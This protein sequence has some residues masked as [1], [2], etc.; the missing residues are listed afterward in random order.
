MIGLLLLVTATGSAQAKRDP[1]EWI[2]AGGNGGYH[3]Y[4]PYSFSEDGRKVFFDTEEPLVPSDIDTQ[5]DT[6]MRSDGVTTLLS[7]GPN[8]GNGPYFSQVAGNSPDGSHA[9]FN[10]SESLVSADTDRQSDLYEWT[11]G[12]TRLVST[13]PSG[14]NGFYDVCFN[15]RTGGLCVGTKGRVSRDGSRV[16]FE[17]QESLVAADTDREYDVYQRAGGET[18]LISTAA[19][20]A[21]GP[22]GSRF[23]GAS[24]DGT[25]VF[26]GT[27]ETLVPEDTPGFSIY[28]RSGDSTTLITRGAQPH[29]QAVSDDGSRV[30]FSTWESLVPLDNDDNTCR[31]VSQAGT[32]FT[33]CDDIYM[34]EGGQISLV[35]AKPDGTGASG[36]DAVFERISNDGSHVFFTTGEQLVPE[37]TD[38]LCERSFFDDDTFETVVYYM[39]CV[40]LYERTAG[41]TKLVSTGPVGGSGKFDAWSGGI[42]SNGRHAFF[43]TSEPMTADDTNGGSDL[44]ERFRDST[45]QVSAGP[46][47]SGGAIQFNSF[48]SANGRR[49]LFETSEPL[50]AADQDRRPDF[51]QRFR[52]RTSLITDFLGDSTAQYPR[53]TPD[54]RHLFIVT[55]ASL[56]SGDADSCRVFSYPPTPCTDLYEV[57]IGP[58]SGPK[59]GAPSG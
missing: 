34:A 40:D 6:Y 41:T 30:F 18:T 17:T 47:G 7:T 22:Y 15:T 45:T 25:R 20:G 16:F 11:N 46:T 3:I 27:Y 12:V 37:D 21:N 13:G 33:P 24:A 43:F 44:Y 8:G 58:G 38:G 14:G 5:Y 29:F 49:V 1:I 4:P 39:P 36:G 53:T 10:T 55:D 51:Y 23:F 35:S 26:F 42:S 31:H 28:E 59:P 54:S 9:F 48:P 57:N 32:F 56:D 19:S 2:S 50:V 52:G